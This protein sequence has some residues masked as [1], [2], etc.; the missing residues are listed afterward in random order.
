MAMELLDSIRCVADISAED[1][2]RSGFA[3]EDLDTAEYEGY[4]PTTTSATIDINNVSVPQV[5]R[6]I[7]RKSHC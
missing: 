4:L 3:M 6:L 1:A 2:F 7:S 5:G